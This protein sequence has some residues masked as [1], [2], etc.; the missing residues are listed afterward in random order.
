RINSYF[1]KC[2]KSLRKVNREEPW[3]ILENFG[4]DSG[5][6]N[7][8]RALYDDNRVILRMGEHS[9]K[10]MG[11]STGLRQGCPLSPTL[12]CLYMSDLEKTLQNTKKGFQVK[13]D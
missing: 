9:S 11:T 3:N 1:P 13:M 7:L 2:H 10:V 8:L 5:T 4:I 12:F 6:L